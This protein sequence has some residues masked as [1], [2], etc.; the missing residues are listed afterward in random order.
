MGGKPVAVPAYDAGRAALDQM[1]HDYE[2]F[3]ELEQLTVAAHRD[4]SVAH[5]ACVLLL[6]AILAEDA[7]EKPE[8]L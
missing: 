7:D 2:W 8:G 5:D 6:R 4:P 1:T 3:A